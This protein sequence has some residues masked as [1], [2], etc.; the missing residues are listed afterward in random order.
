M[1]QRERNTAT[2]CRPALTLCLLLSSIVG[3]HGAT[4]EEAEHHTI[5]HKPAN[6]PAAVD[7]LLALHVEISNNGPRAAKQLD[8]FSEAFDIARWLPELAAD[9]DLEEGPW[10]RVQDV[11]GQLEAIL[12]D[13]LSRNDG[14]RRETYLQYETELDRHQ[15]QL[16]EIKQQ[17]PTA[18][19]SLVADEST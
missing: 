11:A 14:E 10:N 5:A 7:R 2:G 1:N 19:S 13:V 9:S 12:I 3:C 17:F 8:V 4:F 18:A 15:R 6:F 16:V